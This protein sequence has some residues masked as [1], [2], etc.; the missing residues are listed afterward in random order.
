MMKQIIA[1]HQA[2]LGNLT[3]LANH[4]NKINIERASIKLGSVK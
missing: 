4:D 2:H 1:T 3:S